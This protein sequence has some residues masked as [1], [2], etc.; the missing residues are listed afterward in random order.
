MA[1]AQAELS[2]A[3][4]RA[5]DATP[6]LT[7]FGAAD[8][9]AR[10]VAARDDDLTRLNLRE[11]FALGSGGALGI[12]VQGA[13]V[14]AVLV[15]AVPAVI[16]GR[17]DPVLLAVVALLPLALFDVLASLP[18]S[19]L[20]YQRLRG[21]AVRLQEVEDAPAPVRPPDHPP[22]EESFT[23]APAVNKQLCSRG[24]SQSCK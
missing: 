9:A 24:T 12:L 16:D 22:K 6:E 23:T 2:A 17:I 8:R 15:L 7:A 20:A 10:T 19:A 14:S 4:V 21:S 1:P 5:L 3:V 13:A 18:S 11:A